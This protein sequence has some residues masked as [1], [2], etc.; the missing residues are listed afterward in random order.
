MVRGCLS[1]FCCY[2]HLYIGVLIFYIMSAFV[3]FI[4]LCGSSGLILLVGTGKVSRT[5]E[6]FAVPYLEE[7]HF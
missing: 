7:P 6:D 4:E 5:S 1:C 3:V 2:L